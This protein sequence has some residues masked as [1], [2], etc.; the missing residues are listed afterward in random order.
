MSFESHITIRVAD[1]EIGEQVAAR[2]GWKTSEIKRDPLLGD[3]SHFYLT[4]HSGAL[5][6]IYGEVEKASAA[7]RQDGVAILRQ[8]VELIVY[9][10]KKGAG[11]L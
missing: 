1:A 11:F 6:E 5:S 3:D 2:F 10:T 9:D 7:L 8:K 4:K